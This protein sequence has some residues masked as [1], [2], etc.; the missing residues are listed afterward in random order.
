MET[1][2]SKHAHFRWKRKHLGALGFMGE[3]IPSA[4]GI[5]WSQLILLPFPCTD[6]SCV[7]SG[8]Y[9]TR[10]CTKLW[11]SGWRIPIKRFLNT[12]WFLTRKRPAKFTRSWKS[13]RFNTTRKTCSVTTSTLI[14]RP[15]R[16]CGRSWRSAFINDPTLL[17]VSPHVRESGIPFFCCWNPESRD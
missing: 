11:R 10:A 14:Q 2:Y 1:D 3:A 17:A 13:W 12:P 15:E 8:R 16:F 5:A 7:L 4:K 6:T 9:M